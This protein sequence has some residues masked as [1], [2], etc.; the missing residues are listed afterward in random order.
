MKTA[1]L[2]KQ[3]RTEEIR[4]TVTLSYRQIIT[5]T[6]TGPVTEIE[7]IDIICDDVDYTVETVD[8]LIENA[9]ANNATVVQRTDVKFYDLVDIKC[10]FDNQDTDQDFITEFIS[11]SV[12][13]EY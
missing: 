8:E 9:R 1:E 3:N 13:I 7:I 6:E 5:E 2:I 12:V 10:A 4:A 11:K